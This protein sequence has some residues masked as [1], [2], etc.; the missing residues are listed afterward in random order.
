M[1]DYANMDQPPAGDFSD[2]EV[3][4]WSSRTLQLL[5][6]VSVSGP[7]HDVAFSPSAFSH[8]ACVGSQG[9]FFCLIN[10][11]SLDPELTVPIHNH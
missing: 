11:H 4:L 10:T 3:V 6:R 8:L 2:P 5:S 7:I 9:L 1:S